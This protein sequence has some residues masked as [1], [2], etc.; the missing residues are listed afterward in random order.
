MKP[1]P[2]IRTIILLGLV[3]FSLA[4]RI[5]A[6]GNPESTPGRVVFADDFSDP[7]SG[8]NQVIAENGETSYADGVFRILV[9]APNM[10]IWAR[11]GLNLDDVH[12]EVDAIKVGGDRNNRFGV[13][14]RLQ[15]VNFYTFMISSDGYFGIGKVR[16]EIY[17]LVGMSSLQLSEAIKL[18]SAVNHLRAD[19]IGNRLAFYVNGTLLAEVQDDDLTSGDVGLIAGSYVTIG[20]DIRFDDFI[21]SAP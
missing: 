9:N 7:K 8:W 18:G 6:P 17:E 15:G 2:T 16:N 1:K 14:C 11:P 12:I 19:C 13:V 21:V 10:D 4:C 20:V 3:L 5:T